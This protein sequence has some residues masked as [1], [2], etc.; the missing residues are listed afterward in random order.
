VCY[1]EQLE[2]NICVL[3]TKIQ[4]PFTVPLA[5]EF[6]RLKGVKKLSLLHLP[7]KAY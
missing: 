1:N 2:K 4:Y 7:A 5:V 6:N 3:T